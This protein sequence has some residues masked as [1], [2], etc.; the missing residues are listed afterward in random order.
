MP[1]KSIFI[2]KMHHVM[3]D[4]YGVA[5]FMANVSDEWDAEL[6]PHL[7]QFNFWQKCFM[8]LTLPYHFVSLAV[9]YLFY[10]AD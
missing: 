5:S 10:P 3:T 9:Q 7:P 6:L 8:Y 4:G 1:G 2:L